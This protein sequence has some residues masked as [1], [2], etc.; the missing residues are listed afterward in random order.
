MLEVVTLTALSGGREEVLGRMGRAILAGEEGSLLYLCATRPLLEDTRR[1][2][3]GRAEL[4]G[5]GRLRLV[6]FQGLVDLILRQSMEA[7]APLDP[8]VRDL[9]LSQ[10]IRRLA[11]EGRL[12][13]LAPIAE[14]RGLGRSVAGL[15]AELK[16]ANIRPAAWR[17][18][19]AA[20]GKA[21]SLDIKTIDET[22]SGEWRCLFRSQEDEARLITVNVMVFNLCVSA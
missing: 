15:L 20:R 1:K 5:L 10:V 17:R 11:A 22:S 7:V 13:H 16:R 6:L 21:K 2:L 9:L 12:S 3:L 19:A 18:V 14:T 4:P 8:A